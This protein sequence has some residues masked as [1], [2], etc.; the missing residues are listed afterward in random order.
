MSNIANF[1]Q[2]SVQEK[3]KSAFDALSA[4]LNDRVAEKRKDLETEIRDNT[5]ATTES[6]SIKE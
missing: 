6:K 5:F 4:E 1:I 2:Y 3:P